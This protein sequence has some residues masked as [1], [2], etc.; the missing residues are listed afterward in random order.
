MALS[1]AGGVGRAI[2]AAVKCGR[3][4]LVPV[5]LV[6][7]GVLAPQAAPPQPPAAGQPSSDRRT[8]GG[9]VVRPGARILE[10]VANVWVVLH[11][12]GSDSAGPVDSVAT[13]S[14]GT[15]NFRYR[16]TGSEDAIYFV[17]AEY[18]GIAYFSPP[19]RGADVRGE[20]AE[21]VVFDTTSGPIPLGV[22]GRHVVVSAPA[23][24]GSRE[25]VEVYELANDSSRT[26]VAPDS[27]RPTWTALVPE[28]ATDFRVGE[29]D[30]SAQA[31]TLEPGRV[32][33][34]APFA[35]GIRQLSFAYRLPPASFPVSLP[36]EYPIG[37][38]EVLL[39]DSLATA[40]GAGLIEE[41]PVS[42]EGRTFRRYLAQQVAPNAVV[43]VSVPPAP[44][45]TRP[46]Q[47]AV[48]AVVIGTVMLIALA[49]SS[50]ARARSPRAVA[51]APIVD[52]ASTLHVDDLARQIAALDREL[53]SR[54]I[55]TALERSAHEA[56]RAELKR[57]LARA[58]DERRRTR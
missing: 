33:V 50:R 47:L 37:T 17:S 44:A 40:S 21:L 9:R 23:G 34:V 38:L 3:L 48:I 7:G 41:N 57:Q 11:R 28:L 58:L 16:A 49:L 27:T 54:P 19:L 15:Y 2:Q 6:G 13:G 55:V 20:E 12:V 10:P 18:M 42:V 52:V 30:I 8:V 29:G 25:V 22:R 56:R 46:L 14:A 24:D 26:L 35:P 43:R 45:R 39:E 1:D 31:I 32:H 5:L 51:A 36:A 53:E 4:F